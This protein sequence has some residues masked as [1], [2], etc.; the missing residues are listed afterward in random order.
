L[1]YITFS[2]S[3]L[4]SPLTNLSLNAIIIQNRISKGNEGKEYLFEERTESG[5]GWDRRGSRRGK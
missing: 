1:K 4:P 5:G 3:F 2:I